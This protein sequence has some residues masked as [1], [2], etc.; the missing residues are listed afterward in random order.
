MPSDPRPL[1]Y[2]ELEAA[3]G[4]GGGDDSDIYDSIWRDH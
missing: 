1:R 3:D 2:A 4:N